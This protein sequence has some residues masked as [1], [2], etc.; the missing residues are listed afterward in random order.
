MTQAEKRSWISQCVERFVEEYVQRRSVLDSLEWVRQQSS[1][2]QV[3]EKYIHTVV[4]TSYRL[5]RLL[6][7]H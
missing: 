2:T 3:A 5:P 4:N 6:L 1:E 7:A